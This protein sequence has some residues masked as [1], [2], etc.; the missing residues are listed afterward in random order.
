[1]V[2]PC[3]A[4]AFVT[5]EVSQDVT[6]PHGS[7]RFV[8]ADQP[9]LA[10][11]ISD[12]QLRQLPPGTTHEVFEPLG[13][14]AQSAD[15]HL[16]QAH[17]TIG[18]WTWGNEDCCLPAGATSAALR[19]TGRALRLRPGDLL[20]IE[21][22]IGPRTGAPAD[23]DPAHRQAVRLTS[24]TRGEDEL[25]EQPIVEVTWARGAQRG[26]NCR[27]GRGARSVPADRPRSGGRRP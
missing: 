16:H 24:V 3:N 8:S 6:L 26:A 4:R 25:F 15:L 19:N 9:A 14:R 10:P 1:M 17:N 27:G 13:R 2:Q 5:I 7:Y 11:V 22:V 12:E 21:E 20:I 23:A 18:F